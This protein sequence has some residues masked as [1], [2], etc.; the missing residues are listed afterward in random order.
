MTTQ[1]NHNGLRSVNQD[2]EFL[3][4]QQQIDDK[5]TGN[6]EEDLPSSQRN[7]SIVQVVISM[8]SENYT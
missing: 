6:K 3:H 4:L 8:V 1:S 5:K 2:Q 7:L